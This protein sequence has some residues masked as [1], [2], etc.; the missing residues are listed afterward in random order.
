MF[1]Y[2]IPVLVRLVSLAR[3]T[4]PQKHNLMVVDGFGVDVHFD[5]D[6][7]PESVTPEVVRTKII[8]EH[9]DF[10]LFEGFSFQE[11]Y[12]QFRDLP[13]TR[14]GGPDRKQK[15]IYIDEKREILE[16]PRCE[17]FYEND[18]GF[19]L[20]GEPV[21]SDDIDGDTCYEYLN[22]EF[23]GCIFDGFDAPWGCS[24]RAYEKALDERVPRIVKQFLGFRF[25][26]FQS[27][28]LPRAKAIMEAG[29]HIF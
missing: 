26:P 15:A 9:N 29:E 23:G 27:E 17:R 12:Q 20:C 10:C 14:V 7:D 2:R 22:G 21:F 18:E 19:F 13:G 28:L 6:L 8:G 24:V 5:A 11:A 16:L 4:A 1:F 25:V 3:P